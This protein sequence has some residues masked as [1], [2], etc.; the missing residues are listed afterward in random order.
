MSASRKA[1]PA[2][3]LSSTAPTALPWDS[4]KVVVLSKVPK[5]LDTDLPPLEK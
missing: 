4:P 1:S 3:R 2:G 5:L